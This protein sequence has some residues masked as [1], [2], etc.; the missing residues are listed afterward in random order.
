MKKFFQS[1]SAWGNLLG[2]QVFFVYFILGLL[3]FWKLFF[4]YF[5]QDEWAIFGN[6]IYWEK[7]GL[8][9]W[10]R[11]FI[12]EQGTHVAP[13]SNIF[14]YPQFK[15]FSLHFGYY[16]FINILI[17]VL[18]AY[19]LYIL[20]L[21]LTKNKK[22][23]ILTG[24]FFLVNSIVQQAVTWTG[25]SLGTTGSVTFLLLSFIF[26]TKNLIGKNQIKGWLIASFCWILSVLFKETSVFF[27]LVIPLLWLLYSS[28]K[29]IWRF[30]K[31]YSFFVIPFMV[32]L[33]FR[34]MLIIFWG[35]SSGQASIAIEQPNIFV[36]FFKIATFPLKFIAQSF[37]PETYIIAIGKVIVLL[38]YPHF[39][40]G[41]TPD[42]YIVETVASDIVSYLIAFGILGLSVF[43]C[44]TKTMREL[45]I[46]KVVLAA[47]LLISLS[48]L[49]FIF[50]PG[51]AGYISLIDG[52]HLYLTSVFSSILLSSL[53]LSIYKTIGNK[54]VITLL[55]IIGIVGYIGMNILQIRKALNTQMGLAFTRKT[56]LQ[57]IYISYPHIPKNVVF[58][59]ESNTAF[60][61]LPDEEKILPF[62]SGLGQTLLVWY[63]DHGE[64]IPSCFFQGKYLYVLLSQDYKECGGR[65]FGYYRNINLLKESLAANDLSA[66]NVIAFRYNSFTN[67]VIDITKELQNKLQ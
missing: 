10:D 51:K 50:I 2:S 19:L 7:A 35:E 58:Y 60:Y 6:Y 56:I 49:P 21:L 34:V 64:N 23:S 44:T 8:S 46:R 30:F 42:P 14:F 53:L 4:T 17:H 67:S 37:I 26:L 40:Q 28:N 62:Q 29:N 59:T 65:G 48:S 45:E 36:Y 15:L 11:L 38:G 13:L 22:I 66:K 47:V 16:A 12:Y 27:I 25:T 3:T 57:K 1:N 43:L 24:I 20:A 41:G 54:R 55:I 33:L 18:N 9:W 31:L 52:R 32:Y 61:G 63:N 39:V 5:Q